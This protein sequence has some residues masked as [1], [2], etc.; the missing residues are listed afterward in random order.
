M[1]FCIGNILIEFLNFFVK[2][3]LLI[4]RCVICNLWY[5]VLSLSCSILGLGVLLFYF[6]KYLVNLLFMEFCKVKR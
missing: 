3:L 1:Y 6:L 4:F 5:I 2:G